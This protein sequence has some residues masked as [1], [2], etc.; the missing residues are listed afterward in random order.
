MTVPYSP[1][2]KTKDLEPLHDTLLKEFV[3]QNEKEADLF[4][5][6]IHS[7][8]YLSATCFRVVSQVN[9]FVN[10]QIFDD[11]FSNFCLNLMQKRIRLHFNGPALLIMDGFRPHINSLNKVN[12]P[13]LNLY[14][15]II[16]AHSSDQTQPL[17]LGTFGLSKRNIYK[18]TNEAPASRVV[19]QLNKIVSSLW[20]ASCPPAVVKAF[21]SA[22]ICR[23]NG[24]LICH[25]ELARAVR[26]YESSHIDSIITRQE[27][28]TNAQQSVLNSRN[29]P[30]VQNKITFPLPRY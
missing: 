6:C 23:E 4:N 15:L 11:W 22:G 28:L 8:E 9:G 16:P 1:D 12:I 7:K 5:Q 21:R 25:R 2:P 3:P 17:D 19:N 27:P 10:Q 30:P 13:N 26:H 18:I 20:M 29:Q 14:A 24:H